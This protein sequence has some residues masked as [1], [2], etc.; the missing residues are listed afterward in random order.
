MRALVFSL[1]ALLSVVECAA[2]APYRCGG[3]V[4]PA[5]CST[6]SHQVTRNVYI[7]GRS[8]PAAGR[9][10]SPDLSR[11]APRVIT[12]SFQSAGRGQ[13]IW[14]GTVQGHGPVKL[15]LVITRHGSVESIRD[16]GEVTVA[17]NE[18]PV[19]FT[20]KSSLP[21]GTGWDWQLVAAP[22]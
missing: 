17:V 14:R 10:F 12:Q 4:Q 6:V 7:P 22:T 19:W 20:F 16:I 2:A 8:S 9:R 5:P 13:G 11:F 18:R 15:S 1:L 3:R 21:K